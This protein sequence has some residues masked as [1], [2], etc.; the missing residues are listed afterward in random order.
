MYQHFLCCSCG[1]VTFDKVE[2]A[3]KA[4]A[5]VSTS[6]LFSDFIRC[7]LRYIFKFSSFLSYEMSQKGNFSLHKIITKLGIIFPY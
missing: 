7:H 2:S 3:E 5:D 4:I 1:F 6:E